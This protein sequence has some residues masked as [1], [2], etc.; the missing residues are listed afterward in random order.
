MQL[1]YWAIIASLIGLAFAGNLAWQV[2]KIKVENEKAKEISMYIHEGAMAFLHKEYKVLAIF[3]AIIAL[4]TAFAPGLGWKISVSAIIGAILPI[5]AGNIGMRIATIANVRTAEACKKS[6]HKGLDIAFSAGS[7]MGLVVVGLGLLGVTIL[8]MIFRDPEVIFGF[9]FGGAAV[10]LFARVGGG[11]YTKAADVGADLV[12]KVE[13]GI[14]EDDP[15]NPAVIADNVGDNVGD[16]AGMGADLF[17]SYVD[18]LIAAMAIGVLF[19]NTYGL[20][21]V[22]LPLLLGAVGIIATII[23]N[24]IIK[25]RKGKNIYST[26]NGGIWGSAVIIAVASFFVTKYTITENYLNVYGAILTGLIAG[27][28]IGL[29]TEFYT[30][31]KNKPAQMVAKAAETGPGT[32][33][34]SGFALGLMSTLVPVIT[35]VLAL[36][37][38]FAFAGL[39]G[40][41]ILAV[42]MLSTLGI[43]LATDAYGPIADNAAG[44]A[45]MAGLGQETR[46]R[47]EQLDAVGN[48]TAAI[49]KGFAIGSAA[50]TSL[51]LLMSFKQIM[52]ITSVDLMD[53]NVLIGLFLGGL[54]CC[55]FS[56]LCIKAVG[57]AAYQMVNEVRRQFKEIPG[58]MEGT[59]KADYKKCV[60]I[61]TGAAITK[62]IVPGILGVASPVLVGVFLG[63][64]ALAGLLAGATSTG[65][66]LAV[67]MA[68]AGGAWDNAKKYI[69]KG[70]LGGKGS[71]AHKAAVVGDTVGDPFKDTSGPSLNI[72]IKL[73]AIVS[74]VIAPMLLTFGI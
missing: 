14:P 31:E 61:S 27:I 7:V 73:M 32:N 8:Y 44:I 59:G 41:A 30:S 36:Y 67:V 45:E 23:G 26:L 60:E 58:L 46:E 21:A 66:M 62:M 68:N 64:Q 50:L 2:K 63:P 17:E 16:V 56:A 71:P 37:L 39:Y 34:I 29:A 4:A 53:V 25:M 9:G 13:A 20:N 42:G 43:T 35:L 24:V 10:A 5:V 11:I 38:S 1:E 6:L 70:N 69:E 19:K 72:L 3:V 52:H 12:G 18:S 49:G 57:Q 65:F 74:I 54:L 55:I 48:T 40:I 15:R 47:A 22:F 28:I 33:I 51:A